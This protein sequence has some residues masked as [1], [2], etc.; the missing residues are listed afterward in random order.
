MMADLFASRALA[1]LQLASICLT[2]LSARSNSAVA[3]SDGA[4][5]FAV[6]AMG[7]IDDLESWL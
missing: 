5:A 7:L 2:A 3:V 4:A 6:N 1:A